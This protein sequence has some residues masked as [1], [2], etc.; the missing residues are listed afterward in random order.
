MAIHIHSKD[1]K[2]FVFN[3]G[4]FC[5]YS[6]IKVV[7]FQCNFSI[8]SRKLYLFVPLSRR[9]L[10]RARRRAGHPAPSRR[11]GTGSR[12]AYSR[13]RVSIMRRS[14]RPCRAHRSSPPGDRRPCR[15]PP[16]TEG[17]ARRPAR[18]PAAQPAYPPPSPHWEHPHHARNIQ[19]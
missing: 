10:A 16:P 4:H 11:P 14:P 1:L 18:L 6:G 9:R 13:S 12:L 15:T 7:L 2:N 5:R 3:I 19:P 8:F 17:P